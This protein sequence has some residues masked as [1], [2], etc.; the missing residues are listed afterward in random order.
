[1]AEQYRFQPMS[2]YSYQCLLLLLVI[3]YL[4]NFGLLSEKYRQNQ[5]CYLLKYL[6][7][8]ET[9]IFALIPAINKLN[10][11]KFLSIKPYSTQSHSVSILIEHF[12]S[13]FV[14]FKSI[15]KKRFS[16]ID[17]TRNRNQDFLIFL[18][19]IQTDNQSYY[20]KHQKNKSF[21]ICISV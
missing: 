7:V 17:M 4:L 1:M 14:L 9:S 11:Q 10:Y 21:V 6:S 16:V 3:S 18:I 20:S 12:H 15:V 5:I 19:K 2:K 8:V 13:K